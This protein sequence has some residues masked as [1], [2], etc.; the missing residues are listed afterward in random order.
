MPSEAFQ[1]I[2][3]IQLHSYRQTL[4]FFFFLQRKYVRR[5]MEENKHFFPVLTFIVAKKKHYQR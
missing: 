5:E 1:M 4:I 3:D 2:P